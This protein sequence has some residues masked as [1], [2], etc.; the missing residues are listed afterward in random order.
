[1]EEIGKQIAERCKKKGLS[2]QDLAEMSGISPR[3]INSV[4]L[5]KA[6]PSINVLSKMVKP[7]GFVV[8]LSERVRHE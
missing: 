5:G 6:N 7:L 4:E 8:S 1:M 3:T 2:Q